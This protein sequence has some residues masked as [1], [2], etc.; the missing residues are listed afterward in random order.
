M[1]NSP[2]HLTDEHFN[3]DDAGNCHLLIHLAPHSYSYAIVD[4]DHDRL[5]VLVRKTFP[6]HADTISNAERLELFR[7][8]NEYLRQEFRKVKI[9][10]ETKAFTFIP[11]ELYSGNDVSQYSKYIASPPEAALLN[12]DIK[13]YKVRTVAAIEADLES[14]VKNSFQDPLIVS[15]ANPFIAGIYNLIISGNPSGLFLNFGEN[16]FEA[17]FIQSG[18]FEFYNIF[19]IPTA[20]EFNYFLLNLLNQLSI[21]D[22][23][24][25]TLSGEIQ[26]GDENYLRIT[27]YFTQ[28]SFTDVKLMNSGNGAFKRVPTHEFFSL[29]SLDLCE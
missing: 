14:S 25:V 4:K 1:M 3:L 9:S 17:A 28:V 18:I 27:K 22:S 10:V 7:A 29:L 16:C 26:E 12:S 11:E 21:D 15:Q 24:Y 20:D 19:E 13:P 6:A 5:G 8:E 23:T 2:I